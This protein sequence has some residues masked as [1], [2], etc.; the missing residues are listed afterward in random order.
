MDTAV[1][2]DNHH[3]VARDYNNIGSVWDE[4][5][6]KEKALEFYQKALNILESVYGA[7]HSKTKMVSNKIAKTLPRASKHQTLT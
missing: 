3:Y 4:L 1:Y 6:E 7:D 5:R 2:G